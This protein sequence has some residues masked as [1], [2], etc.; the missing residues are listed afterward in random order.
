MHMIFINLIPQMVD[1]WTGNFNGMDQG[2]ESYSIDIA[3]FKILGEIIESSGSTMPTSYGCRVP[4][5]SLPHHGN[6]TAEAWS[7]L[8]ISRTMS[9]IREGFIKWVQDYEQYYYQYSFNRMQTCTVNIHYLLHVADCIQHLGPVWCYWLFPM[10]RFCSFV[11]GV[12][13]SRRFPFE[14]I[15]RRIRDTAQLQVIRHLYGSHDTLSFLN[16]DND[17]D[18]DP[19]ADGVNAFPEYERALLYGRC[20]KKLEIH[21]THCTTKFAAI[22]FRHLISQ[23]GDPITA[24]G[25]QKI[26]SDVRDSSFVRYALLVDRHAHHRNVQPEL[27]PASQYGELQHIFALPL[28][29]RSPENNANEKRTLLLALISEAPVLVENTLEYKVISYAEG[30]LKSGEIVDAKNIQCL[31]GRVLDR[32]RS[33]RSV[34][35]EICGFLGIRRWDACNTES[36]DPY[37]Y[38]GVLAELHKSASSPGIL[39]PLESYTWF[40]NGVAPL[41]SSKKIVHIHSV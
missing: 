33:V 2:S 16:P 7:I 18:E 10:E 25:C 30:E 38:F 19:E 27:Q 3:L 17:V 37:Q 23:G 22:L 31:L 5:I 36:R 11:G 29:P 8:R 20:A 34:P 39:G 9:S 41:I 35:A 21:G 12:V 24:K 6:A 1:I 32:G 14:N 28:K 4:N 13:K 40:G 15:A 26:R